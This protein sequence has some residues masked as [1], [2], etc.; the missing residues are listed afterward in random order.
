[1]KKFLLSLLVLIG[2]SACTEAAPAVLKG[3]TF[4]LLPAKEITLSFDKAENRFYGKAVNN[5]FGT[6]TQDKNIISFNPGGTTMMMGP[7]DKMKA[8]REF[9]ISLSKIKSAEMKGKELILSGDD[10]TLKFEEQ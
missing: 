2:I 1:M 10:I 7:E 4:V 5:Y 9:L 8:E 6:Y 3:K